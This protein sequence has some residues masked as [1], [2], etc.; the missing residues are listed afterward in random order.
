M[1]TGLLH[2]HSTLR[3]VV[4][5]LLVLMIV[6]SWMGRSGNRTWNEGD[7]KSALFLMIACHIQLA[8]GLYQWFT[9]WGLPQIQ[10]LGM[11]AA[12]KNAGIRFFAIEHTVGM[13]AAIVLATMA[14]SYSKK[15][16]E[17]SAK[18]NRLFLY[19]AL[20]F[21][22]IMVFIPWPFREVGE[23]RSWFPGM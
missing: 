12:M 18:Y 11:A 19:Y 1:Y 17:D 7:R 21:I 22:L 3:W 9:R 20:T 6:R 5:I 2:L 10:E 16:V 13:I 14:Y 8:I 4:L 23:G 15:S